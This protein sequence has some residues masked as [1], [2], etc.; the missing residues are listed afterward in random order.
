MAPKKERAFDA[1]AFL[2]SAGLGKR[3]VSYGRKEVIFSQGDPANS[4]MYV[5]TGGIQLSV[6]SHTGREAIVATLVPG[7]FLGEGALAGHSVRLET[8]VAAM[9]STVAVV[10]LRQMI[11]L[12]HS[13]RAFSD[14]FIA[15]M[16]V[17]NARLEADLVDQLFNSS[18][19]R[20]ART[21]LLLARYGKGDTPQPMLPPIS[22]ET[23]A[24]MI[25]TTRSRVNFFLN[26]FRKLGFI[27]YDTGGLT[28]NPS[29]LAVVVHE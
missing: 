20:L 21:L 13:Q 4:V 29:L 14:R 24:E 18:E 10:P 6:L 7:D 19:K 9:A 12:L 8:A 17:R 1:Q 16:L 3:V 22:Q 2:E 11:H 26:K 27:E 25:G 15:H 5:R 28:V 23:L